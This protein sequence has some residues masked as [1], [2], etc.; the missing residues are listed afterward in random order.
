MRDAGQI[1]VVARSIDDDD[2]VAAGQRLDGFLQRP[3]ARGLFLGRGVIELLE[4]EVLGHAEVATDVAGPGAPVLDVMGEALLP[5]V[6]IDGGDRLSRLDQGDRDMHGDGGFSRSALLIAD[7]DHT[8]RQCP[9]RTFHR[10]EIAPESL[11]TFLL[12]DGVIG[13]DSADSRNGESC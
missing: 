12:L 3:A 6:E 7:D 10:H 5:G 1:I 13:L 2:A 4:A 11:T 9:H 8:S